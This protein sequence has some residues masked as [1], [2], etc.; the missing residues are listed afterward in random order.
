MLDNM[1]ICSICF[2][3]FEPAAALVPLAH[4]ARGNASHAA[5]LFLVEGRLSS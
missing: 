1:P 4:R 2:R 5:F 3:F